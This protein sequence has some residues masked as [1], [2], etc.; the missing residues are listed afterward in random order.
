MVNISQFENFPLE[1]GS[2]FFNNPP[3]RLRFQGV[4][5]PGTI[6]FNKF[7]IIIAQGDT[8][9]SA[10][11]NFGLYSLSG[12]TMSLANSAT[13][14]VNFTANGT[15]WVTFVT[16]ATQDITPGNWY[17]VLTS[18]LGGV[19][20]LSYLMNNLGIVIESNVGY[21]GGLVRADYS[22]STTVL[23]ASIHTSQFS[24]EGNISS[25]LNAYRVAYML[26]SA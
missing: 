11:M 15:S 18:T 4:Y 1:Y 25:A 26:I 22:V 17:F 16:S 24:K 8:G 9:A 2:A 3:L 12:A 23:P 19:S 5:I 6:P 13:A 7:A 14:T 21:G 10:T 20:S